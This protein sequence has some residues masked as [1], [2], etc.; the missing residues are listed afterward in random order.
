MLNFNVT[1]KSHLVQSKFH[2]WI[3]SLNVIAYEAKNN[4]TIQQSNNHLHSHKI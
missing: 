3:V 4:Q 2:Y 1:T